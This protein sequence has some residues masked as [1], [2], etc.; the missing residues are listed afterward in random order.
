MYVYI[1]I[2]CISNVAKTIINHPKVITI[3]WLVDV[4]GI[5]L[6]FP[7]MGGRHG[8]VLPTLPSIVQPG[9]S[10]LHG[11]HSSP[12]FCDKLRMEARLETIAFIGIPLNSWGKCTVNGNKKNN[13]WKSYVLLVYAEEL[14]GDHFPE[15]VQGWLFIGVQLQFCCCLRQKSQQPLMLA[16]IVALLRLF[17]K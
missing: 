11:S 14:C 13:L 16:I 8:I 7:V 15:H 2:Y 6:P 10:R 17:S 12:H 5:N 1:Y 4:G 9:D 3:F